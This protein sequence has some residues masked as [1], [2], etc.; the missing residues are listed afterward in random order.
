MCEGRVGEEVEIEREGEED[1][2]IEESFKG[3]NSKGVVDSTI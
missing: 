3:W 2:K 1:V